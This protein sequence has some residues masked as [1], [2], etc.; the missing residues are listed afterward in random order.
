METL[1]KRLEVLQREVADLKK[2]LFACDVTSSAERGS[3]LLQEAEQGQEVIEATFARALS[4]MGINGAPIGAE[5]LQERLAVAGWKPE[6]NE[7]SRGIIE[8]REE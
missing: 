2:H 7:L 4:E 5:K 8:M 6:D 3:R 1:E